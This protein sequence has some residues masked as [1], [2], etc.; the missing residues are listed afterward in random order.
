M[1]RKTAVAAVA[2]S[3]LA[4][5]AAADAHVTLQ[6]STAAA[7]AFTVEN[8]RVP[9]ERDKASTVKVDVQLPHG[10]VFASYE[11]KIGWSVKVTK[12]KLAKPIQTDDG[13]IDEEV[14][15]IT[16][17]GHGPNGK[18]GPG[19][20]MDFPLSVQIPGK[21]GDKL[22]FKAI[23]TYSNGEV[24][25]W[26]GAPDSET[27]APIVTVTK[28]QGSAHTSAATPAPPARA[29]NSSDSN[30]GGGASKGLGV[31]ALIVGA[32]GLVAGL[33]AF[34]ARRRGLGTS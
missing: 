5:P 34:G 17:T 22:T 27:P 24:V 12:A 29:G 19:Q 13:P 21:A 3:A 11:P 4:A 32:L 7:G 10:F 1:Q 25:R 8:V 20:F 9:N 33:A 18:I 23:Q 26:I 31:T 16:F 15:R 28:A 30:D 2:A 14:R 6:P